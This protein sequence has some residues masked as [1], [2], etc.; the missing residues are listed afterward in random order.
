LSQYQITLETVWTKDEFEVHLK[1]F[2]PKEKRSRQSFVIASISFMLPGSYMANHFDIPSDTAYLGHVEARKE[3]RGSKLGVV[4]VC[5]ALCLLSEKK[6]IRNI[7]LHAADQG[8]GKL[9]EY[10][11]ELG[12]EMRDKKESLMVAPIHKI[13][14]ICETD[15]L[16]TRKVASRKR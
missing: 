3:Y 8:S 7:S 10:Y 13:V 1:E 5:Y 4:M 9:I 2:H 15:N 14:K 16:F 12:F 11:R 6:H